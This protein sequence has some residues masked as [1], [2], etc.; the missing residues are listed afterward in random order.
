MSTPDENAQDP[1]QPEST[2][3]RA[4][5][6]APVRLGRAIVPA[7][8]AIASIVALLVAFNSCS[9]PYTQAPSITPSASQSPSVTPTPSETPSP[10]V[11]PR[12]SASASAT[13][14]ASPSASPTA[15]ATVSPSPSAALAPKLPVTV[16]N[17]TTVPG[18][19]ASYALKVRSA[20][21]SVVSVGNW[22]S[23]TV[24]TT[25]IFY[26]SGKRTSAARLAKEL[27]G[28][29][30]IAAALSGMT[31]RGLTIVVAR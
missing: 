5:R 20:G 10:S 26:P 11:S 16:L 29:Q 27:S 9:D 7:I 30:E 12:A 23:T 31:D 19:A 22:R 25:T 8:L 21:W 18:L 2:G 17:G 13:S 28:N 15:P 24:A 4:A 1:W 14:T 3:R 6:R